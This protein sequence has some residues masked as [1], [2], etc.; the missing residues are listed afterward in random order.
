MYS[1]GKTRSMKSL[2]FGDTVCRRTVLQR[3]DDRFNNNALASE[4]K[5]TRS[6]FLIKTKLSFIY[7]YEIHFSLS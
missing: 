2:S 7:F 5:T 4:T 6:T 3:V 1:D